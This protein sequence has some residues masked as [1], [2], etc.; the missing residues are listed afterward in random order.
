MSTLLNTK[1][2][3][4]LWT[5]KWQFMAVAFVVVLGVSMYVAGLVSY[6]NLFESYTTSYRRLRFADLWVG[7]DQAP[8]EVV[9]V[10]EKMPGIAKVVGRVNVEYPLLL[11]GD[12]DTSVV[13]R[14]IGLPAQGRPALNDVHVVSGRYFKPQARREALLETGFA[15]SHRIE[16]GD[17]I[18]ADVEG[19]TED[20]R[21]VGLVQSPEYIVA[22]R[23]K[24]YGMPT[25]STFGVVFVPQEQAQESFNLV[26][27]ITEICALVEG[28]PSGPPSAAR[29]SGL[30]SKHPLVKAVHEMLKPYGAGDPT[31]QD[32]QASNE[33]L[34][35]DLQSIQQLATIFPSLF[36][37]AAAMTIYVLMTRIVLSQRPHIGFLRAS[38]FTQRA[39]I[40]HY[41][42]YTLVVGL[43]GGLAATVAGYYMGYLITREYVT[44]LN[45]PYLAMQARWD[46]VA[47]GIAIS[48]LTCVVAGFLPA[49]SAGMMPPAVAMRDEVPGP[50]RR[51]A[52]DRLLTAFASLPYTLK[53]P[54]RNLVRSRRRT[55]STALGIASGV[56]LVLVSAM[57]LDAI[58]FS[59]T[60]YFGKMQVYDA[61][62]QFLP[63]QSADMVY[64]LS[65]RPGVEIAEAGL[66]LP[67]ELERQGKKF[68]TMLLGLPPR[69][70]LYRVLDTE[71]KPTHL[72]DDSLRI[73]NLVRRRLGLETGDEVMVRYSFS[74]K[75]VPAE[76]MMRIGPPIQQPATTLVY[77][78]IDIV[79]K[80]FGSSLHLANRPVT[81]VA[82]KAD[83]RY[84]D[85]L[86]HH[87]HNLPQ[88][89]AVEITADTKKEL[90]AMMRFT[91]IFISVMLLF[92]G[93]LAFAI[94]FNTLSINVIE[95]TREVASL[96]TL[97]FQ[98]SQIARML[99]LEN[100]M[101]AVLGLLLGF[102]L[103]R[104]LC[105]W[106]IKTYQSETVDLQVILYPRTY[107]LTAVGMVLIVIVAQIPSLRSVSRLD[108]AKATKERTG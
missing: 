21:V 17:L 97:G 107:V 71:G 57:F 22:V 5:S 12:S 102:P 72:T 51:L 42:S 80:L 47:T 58:D 49:W 63:D 11:A 46:I 105:N 14:F 83:P 30:T 6:H 76:G 77:A 94:V 35:I 108:L 59:I 40:Q 75:E 36:L 93:S 87:L 99:T 67:V 91:Y 88:A 70:K 43:L 81:G 60:S 32:E 27:K 28:L 37:L 74:S 44:T 4:D 96:R 65:L 7:C 45:I 56:S 50:T 62:V 55:F 64:H 73:G 48:L 85:S 92:G 2:Y 86:R 84:M 68:S 106:L 9:R 10:I 33:A 8:E 78:N 38:G 3:R 26:G 103:G 23:N 13:G 52:M 104:L 29:G 16:P 15:R 100:L 19:S 34:R 82:L 53:V 39:V 24:Q 41:L 98:N 61:L 89:A 90:D 18:T 66:S 95:R 69:G 101:V 25:P 31:V 54:L 20:F 1:L 79:R